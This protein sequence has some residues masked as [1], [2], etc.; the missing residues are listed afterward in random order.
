VLVAAPY[1]PAQHVWCRVTQ[2]LSSLL[3]EPQNKIQICIL[4]RAGYSDKFTS[5]AG[6]ARHVTNVET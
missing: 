2:D 3:G 1:R 4:K 5:A 6:D